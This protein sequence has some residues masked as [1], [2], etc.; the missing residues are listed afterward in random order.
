[1]ERAFKDGEIHDEFAEEVPA[2]DGHQLHDTA[3]GEIDDPE[4]LDHE[5]KQEA[6]PISLKTPIGDEEE[7][8]TLRKLRSPVG[9]L[10]FQGRKDLR[11]D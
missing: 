5:R 8:D 10:N 1:M 6:E 3:I 11:E 2:G 4:E 7:E 9:N